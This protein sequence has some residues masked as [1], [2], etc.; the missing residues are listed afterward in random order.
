MKITIYIPEAD[1]LIKTLGIDPN[2]PAQRFH[3]QNIM[4]RMVKY[5]P[6]V[7]GTLIKTMVIQ[8]STKIVVDAPQA[9]YL[10]YGNRMVNSKTGKGPMWI[11][12]IPGYR[13]PKG[14]KLVPT[15]TPLKYNTTHNPLAGPYWD[16]RL[17][18]NEKDQIIAELE[19][20]IGSRL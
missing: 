11:P 15:T 3:T 17:L 4:R 13:W 14:A 8:S 12:K 16:R 9:K 2:G 1:Q 10:Y 6:N 18:E 19:A 7:T 20:Y 5:M